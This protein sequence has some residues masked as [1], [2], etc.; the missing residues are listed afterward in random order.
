M[1]L[2]AE[3]YGKFYTGD[4]YIILKV[5]NNFF[6]NFSKGKVVFSFFFHYNRNTV[7]F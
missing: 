3:F 1:Y 5:W 7:V 6:F 4:C 2:L